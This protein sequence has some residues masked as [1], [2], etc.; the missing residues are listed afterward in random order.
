M[1]A[2]AALA[3]KSEALLELDVELKKL[4]VAATIRA[5][6]RELLPMDGRDKLDEELAKIGAPKQP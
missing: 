6:L 4:R 5:K 3:S 1:E 2:I